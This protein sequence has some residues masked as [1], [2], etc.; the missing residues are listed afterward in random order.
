MNASVHS[1]VVSTRV[2]AQA[3]CLI[4]SSLLTVAFASAPLLAAESAGHA[5]IAGTVSNTAT[6][7]LLPG[8]RIE[9]R[10][11]ALGV[12][13]DDTGSYV[14]TSVPAGTHELVASYIGLD[15]IT[16]TLTPSARSA[17]AAASPAGPPPT[18]ATSTS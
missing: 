11:L 17:T 9:I 8:A 16:V 2:R 6:G 7:N 13:A 10:A 5:S 14:L 12:L 3:C 18:I 4:L 15:A 1:R